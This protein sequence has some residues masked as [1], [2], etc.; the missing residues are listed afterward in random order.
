[1]KLMDKKVIYF[2]LMLFFALGSNASAQFVLL[3]P[4]DSADCVSKNVRFEWTAEQ[5]VVSF[6]LDVAYDAE[7]FDLAYRRGNLSTDFHDADLP[8]G[9]TTYY[10]RVRVTYLNDSR[11]TSETR[12]FKTKKDAPELI[13][14]SDELT[15]MPKQIQFRWSQ[16]DA[17]YYE[18]IVSSD[19][20]L[21]DTLH[22]ANE[23]Q[24]T[25]ALMEMMMYNMDYYWSVKGHY[26]ECNTDWM[27]PNKFT[28]YRGPVTN[29]HP[30]NN[31]KG[32]PLFDSLF[33][34]V[35][36]E[37]SHDDSV[38]ADSYRLQLADSSEFNNIVIDTVFSDTNMAIELPIP[39]IYNQRFFWRVS[40][41]FDGCE[42][43]WSEITSFYTPYEAPEAVMPNDGQT[44]VPFRYE[45]RWH[46]V[47][48]GSFY[49]FQIADSADFSEESI[50]N[51]VK[52]IDSI[53]IWQE[54]EDNMHYYF[55][56]V[57]AEDGSNVGYW[58]ETFSFMTT[59][60]A[61]LPVYPQ[62]SSEGVDRTFNLSWQNKGENAQYDLIIAEDYDFQEVLYDTT[63][64]DTNSF[65]VE[66]PSYNK[67]YYWRVRVSYSD[68]VFQCTGPWSDKFMFRTQLQ[69]P[70]LLMPADSAE[71]VDL[72]SDFK[73]NEVETAEYYNFR[74]SKDPEFSGN[75]FYLDSIPDTT[76]TLT[77]Y[78]LEENTTYYWSARATNKAGKSEWS[79]GF[80]FTTGIDVPNQ[81]ILISP[82]DNS[83]KIETSTTLKW[84]SLKR[85]DSYRVRLSE[86]SS[87][88]GNNLIIDTVI[89]DTTIDATGLLNYHE[90]Y[91]KVQAM[92]DKGTGDIS[93]TWMFR[94]IHALPT[95]APELIYP[96]DDAEEMPTEI[97]L[98][99]DEVENAFGYEVQ[100]ATSGD[101]A[102]GTLVESSRSNWN[103]FAYL[104]GLDEKT[105][106]FW[107]VRA[108]S[109]A[110]DAPWSETRSF[111]TYDPVS[112]R[113]ANDPFGSYVTPNP[114]KESAV[115]HLNLSAP[116]RV[117]IEIFDIN[118]VKVLDLPAKQMNRGKRQIDLNTAE[119]NSGTYIYKIK[120]G[121]KAHSGRFIISK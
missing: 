63:A 23:I 45:M 68:T 109:E 42:T 77:A 4:S 75:F 120:A 59:Q 11:D 87:F 70:V 20:T 118:G 29:V 99:W 21:S 119:L 58:S 66:F 53:S 31:A 28:T 46:S 78:D 24:D 3:N 9:D 97:T 82:E 56:R 88:T 25:T 80:M 37:W 48:D 30:A 17:D 62:D 106:Y 40:Q 116:E 91:W 12:V 10:W 81:V 85:A 93:E 83:K 74:I 15:C 115:L 110:G 121:N 65:Y 32:M 113:E 90:Y 73:W 67:N 38:T 95:E 14:P 102:Q 76:I 35:K 2:V 100:V 94:T 108:W 18:L 98:R 57:R 69:S 41:T 6:D 19:S 72:I 111:M 112:V 54:F 114:A 64:L 61:P 117:D 52:N 33:F 92:N 71:N 84:H 5:N 86:R 1:M 47:P 101:F 27:K 103:N 36:F 49:T 13:Y 26:P 7:F 79:E 51:E 105:E 44:C 104:Y 22:H 43:E 96:A 39:Q 8:A 16:T 60:S 89:T 50:V 34:R 107:R 55:W